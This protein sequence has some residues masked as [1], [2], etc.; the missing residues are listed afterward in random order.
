[1]SASATFP[2][3]PVNQLRRELDRLFEGVLGSPV[4]ATVFPP[5]N[6]WEDNDAILVEAEVPGLGMNDFEI[7]VQGNELT[8]KGQRRAGYGET[9]AG[10]GS[11]VE[12][13]Q[14]VFHRRERS[15]GQ[16]ARFM[17]LPTEVDPDKV[18]ASLKDGVLTIKLPK[19]D[20]ARARR[21]T[22]KSDK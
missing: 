19:S 18:E 10:S 1:M 4:E 3:F 6:V 13:S 21:I 20:R 2:A 12:E 15:V 7:L 22:V 5:L 16:F 11:N 17:S 14:A 9:N 8:I